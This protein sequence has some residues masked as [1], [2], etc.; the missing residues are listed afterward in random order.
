MYQFRIEK[1]PI[2]RQTLNKINKKMKIAKNQIF[3]IMVSN[4]NIF[5]LA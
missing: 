5:L 2:L 3:V 1:N 4:K